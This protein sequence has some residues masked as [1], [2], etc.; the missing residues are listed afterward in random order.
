MPL[1]ASV[2]HF[3][4]TPFGGSSCTATPKHPACAHLVLWLI[5]SA[6]QAAPPPCGPHPVVSAATCQSGTGQQHPSPPATSPGGGGALQQQSRRHV[7]VVSCHGQGQ[8]GR[9]SD[10]GVAKCVQQMVMATVSCSSCWLRTSLCAAECSCQHSVAVC[11]VCCYPPPAGCSQQ[12]RCA[13]QCACRSHRCWGLRPHAAAGAAMPGCLQTP[14]STAALLT[15]PCPSA[16]DHLQLAATC[17]TNKQVP[18]FSANVNV[19]E[20]R[21]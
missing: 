7:C 2:N 21:A 20:L 15:R 13:A 3:P 8:T 12:R 1:G 4:A 17:R 19:D 14:L 9:D 11:V 16:N 5:G 18:N 10:Q 6:R